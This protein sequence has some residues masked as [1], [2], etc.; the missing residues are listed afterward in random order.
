MIER[1]EVHKQP[2]RPRCQTEAQLRYARRPRV[3]H[4]EYDHTRNTTRTCD[5]NACVLC[6]LIDAQYRT[7]QRKVR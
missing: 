6:M 2:E 1:W 4:G 3:R 5:V 7:G